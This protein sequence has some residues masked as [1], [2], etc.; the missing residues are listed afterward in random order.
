MDAFLLIMAGYPS[1]SLINTHLRPDPMLATAW[2]RTHLAEQSTISRT[3][4]C[5]DDSALLEL[6]SIS[7]D[8]WQQHTRLIRHDWRSPLVFDL[9][10]SPL[11]ASSNAESS[12][13][14]Y[15]GEK[16]QPAVN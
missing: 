14:G 9:D 2:N 8:F 6:R 11:P 7:W 3:L 15:L 5:M 16:T 4:D 10:L 12:T 13:K 1:L